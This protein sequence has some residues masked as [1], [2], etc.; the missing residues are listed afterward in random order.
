MIEDICARIVRRLVDDLFSPAQEA[1][2]R[3][4][5]AEGIDWPST[6]TLLCGDSP[7][8]EPECVHV[9]LCG[10]HGALARHHRL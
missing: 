10:H 1:I 7:Q 2:P 5:D 9:L 4:I 8:V 6:Y 3:L